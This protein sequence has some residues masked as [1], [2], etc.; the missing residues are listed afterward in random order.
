MGNIS[1]MSQDKKDKLFNLP[2]TLT[3]LRI[4]LIPIF[5]TLM[6]KRKTPEAFAVFLFAGFT[7]VLDG[8]AARMLHMKTKIGAFLDPAA[9][10]LLMTASFIILT[11]PTLNSPN[12]IPLWLTASVVGRDV[13][14]ASGAFVL[15]K[16]RGQTTFLPSLL[17]K[18][19]TVLQVMVPLLVLFLNYRQVSSPLLIWLYYLTLL[20]TFLSAVHYAFI[21][22]RMFSRPQDV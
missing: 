6:V 19:C 16:L 20:F 15:Y 1:S 8:F 10:K 4:L 22:Y 3:L 2:N 9:D 18:T 14:I 7:D 17:G 21:G 11:I 13:I 12:V 5:L